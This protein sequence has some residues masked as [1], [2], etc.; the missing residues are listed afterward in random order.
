MRQSEHVQSE[1][2]PTG[3]GWGDTSTGPELCPTQFLAHGRCSFFERVKKGEPGEVSSN[4]GKGAGRQTS[5]QFVLPKV[6]LVNRRDEGLSGLRGSA[7]SQGWVGWG[8]RG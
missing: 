2:V 6:H 7:L 3:L 5:A 4:M 8:K 1:G